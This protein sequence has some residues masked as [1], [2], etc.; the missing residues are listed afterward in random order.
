MAA[1][2]RPRD[3]RDALAELALAASFACPRSNTERQRTLRAAIERINALLEATWLP[4]PTDA[5]RFVTGWIEAGGSWRELANAVNRRAGQ[6]AA[7]EHHDR[8]QGTLP[9]EAS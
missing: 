8:V 4:D 6:A 9:S 2:V 5:D 1:A 3:L 7:R